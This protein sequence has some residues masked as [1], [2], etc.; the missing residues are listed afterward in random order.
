MM[1]LML[2]GMIIQLQVELKNLHYTMHMDKKMWIRKLNERFMSILSSIH[3]SEEQLQEG[4][5]EVQEKYKDVDVIEFD[6]IFV[7]LIGYA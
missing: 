3:F 6:E 5:K 4:I 7:T 1:V 2:M